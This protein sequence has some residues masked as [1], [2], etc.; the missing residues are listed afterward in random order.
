MVEEV[1]AL[2]TIGTTVVDEG[3]IEVVVEEIFE[4]VVRVDS[5]ID[6]MTTM[7]GVIVMVVAGGIVMAKTIIEEEIVA[8]KVG[9]PKC[10]TEMDMTVGIVMVVVVAADMQIGVVMMIEVGTILEIVMTSVVVDEVVMDMETGIAMVKGTTMSNVETVMVVVSNV[11]IVMVAG[12]VEDSE[13][14]IEVV[15]EVV[16]IVEGIVMVVVVVEGTAMVVVVTVTEEEMVV[17]TLVGMIEIEEALLIEVIEVLLGEE[18][19]DLEVVDVEEAG[20]I[21]YFQRSK[22]DTLKIQAYTLRTVGWPAQLMLEC[23]YIENQTC[24]NE[25]VLQI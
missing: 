5:V 6:E 13:T 21:K 19:E 11:G 24:L 9:D 20:I 3:V 14:G 18:V 17:E 25:D 2:M 22:R 7:T 12:V 16:V 8:T 4:V 10:V 1:V 23:H 15:T